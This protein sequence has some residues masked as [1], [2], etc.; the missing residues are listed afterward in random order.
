MLAATLLGYYISELKN[1]ISF[2]LKEEFIQ[3]V[4]QFNFYRIDVVHKMRR[5]N[6]DQI[7]SQLQK[8]KPCFDE[9]YDMYDKIRDDFRV[10]FHGFKK[11]EFIDLL[12]EEEYQEYFGEI[13]LA[14]SNNITVKSN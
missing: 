11:D 7:S 13:D 6:M 5:T 1:S 9:I 14:E 10:I 2:Y 4:E 12:T 3:R 8:I